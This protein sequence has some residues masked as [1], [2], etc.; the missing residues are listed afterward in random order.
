MKSILQDKKEC[1]ICHAAEG[2][3]EHHIF[4]GSRRR[5]SEKHGCKVW[6][7]RRHH[8]GADGVQLNARKSLMLKREAQRR[9]EQLYGHEAFIAA[10]GKNYLEG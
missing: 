7:C 2:L 5:A 10:F 4:G 3:E 9:Y 6:L 1:Y 8:T